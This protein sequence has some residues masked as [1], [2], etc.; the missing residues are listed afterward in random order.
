MSQLTDEI[1][2]D[3]DKKVIVF[4]YNNNAITITGKDSSE[5]S[6]AEDIYNHLKSQTTSIN[7]CSIISSEDLVDYNLKTA[8]CI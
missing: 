6:L 2:M 1:K 8:P 7:I 5:S 4:I 3:F